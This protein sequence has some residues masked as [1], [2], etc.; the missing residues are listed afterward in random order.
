MGFFSRSSQPDSPSKAPSKPSSSLPNH[1]S[2]SPSS[3]SNVVNILRSKWV[4]FSLFLLFQKSQITPQRNKQKNVDPSTS[5][6]TP[7]APNTQPPPPVPLPRTRSPPSISAGEP[8]SDTRASTVIHNRQS[9]DPITQVSSLC[10]PHTIFD[11]A[12]TD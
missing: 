6:S 8:S 1:I 9:T 12:I 7:K 3:S 2:E 5:I 11:L 10:S 4:H